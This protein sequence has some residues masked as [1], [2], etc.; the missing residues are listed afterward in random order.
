MADWVIGSTEIVELI[1]TNYGLRGCPLHIS[2]VLQNPGI[3]IAR[4]LLQQ[5]PL[6][7]GAIWPLVEH[8]ALGFQVGVHQSLESL[9]LVQLGGEDLRPDG[10]SELRFGG[11]RRRRRR[12]YPGDHYRRLCRHW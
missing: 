2:A 3:R 11:I 9:R 10:G 8:D 5:L 4:I 12:L 6:D 1:S 7:L